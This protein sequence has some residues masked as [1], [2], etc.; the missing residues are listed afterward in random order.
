M[1]EHVTL[2][3]KKFG[4]PQCDMT[5]RRFDKAGVLDKVEI[6]YIDQPENA[7]TLKNLK[8]QGLFSAP[9]VKVSTPITINGS[10]TD[11]WKGFNPDAVD[12]AIDLLS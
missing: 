3:A 2:Y 4:C 1:S 5:K 6:I 10:L 9:I 12:Q 8:N 11:T 7:D